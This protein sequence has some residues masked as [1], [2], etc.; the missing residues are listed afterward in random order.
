MLTLPIARCQSCR[1]QSH[2][3][4][5]QSPYF[6]DEGE[7]RLEDEACNHTSDQGKGVTLA[8]HIDFLLFVPGVMFH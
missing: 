4:C 6:E 7:A 2:Q 3:G 5:H 8:Y 1:R